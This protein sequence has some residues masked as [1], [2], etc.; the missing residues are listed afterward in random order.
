MAN[1]QNFYCTSVQVVLTTLNA[2]NAEYSSQIH[3]NC[4]RRYFYNDVDLLNTV[5]T[6]DFHINYRI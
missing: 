4:V 5:K 6:I 1:F 3:F 2:F